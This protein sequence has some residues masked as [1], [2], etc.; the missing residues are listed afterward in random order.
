[1]YTFSYYH[2]F[3]NNTLFPNQCS[4]NNITGYRIYIVLFIINYPVTILKLTGGGE[5]VTYKC[6]TILSM[7]LEH[8]QISVSAGIVEPVPWGC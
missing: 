4:I 3:L 5:E 7:G 6:Y 2:Y 1:M 8:M